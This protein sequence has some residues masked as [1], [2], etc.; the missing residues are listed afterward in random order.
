MI[1]QDI[2]EDFPLS[3]NKSVNGSRRLAR[4]KVLQIL[5]AYEISDTKWQTI[6]PHIFFRKFNFGDNEEIPNKKL[7]TE[8]E[9][10]ELDSDIPIDWDDEEIKFG[11]DLVKYTIENKSLVNELIIKFAANW[12]LER[13]AL[14]DKLLMHI[15]I[16]ELMKFEE[17]PPKV[18]I[19]EAIDIGKK[20]STPKSGTF[21]NGVLDSVHL[22]LKKDK[23]I[24]KSGRG[25]INK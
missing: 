24:T 14:I 13:I 1:M 21:I 23:L 12:K 25:L 8:E 9:I 15:A 11:R 18:S 4:E 6:F 17:I 7:L 10:M 22:Q 20:Y 16:T 2:A 5:V 19:N 3:K